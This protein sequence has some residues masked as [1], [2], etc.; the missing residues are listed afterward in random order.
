MHDIIYDGKQFNG[1]PEL[2][3]EMEKKIDGL[4]S[5]QVLVASI[6]KIDFRIGIRIQTGFD[7]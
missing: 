5:R 2:E 6:R 3:L 4:W 1:T 7:Q